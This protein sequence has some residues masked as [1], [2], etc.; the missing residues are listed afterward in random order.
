MGILF[1]DPEERPRPRTQRQHVSL[2]REY[3]KRPSRTRSAVRSLQPLEFFADSTDLDV[4]SVHVFAEFDDGT[5][6]VG[7]VLGCGTVNVKLPATTAREFCDALAGQ[8]RNLK[9][10]RTE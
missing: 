6:A 5:V 3:A 1:D 10:A 9:L 8:L 2:R 7:F 4:T